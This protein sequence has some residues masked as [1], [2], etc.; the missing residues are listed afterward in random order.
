MEKSRIVTQASEERNYH[1]FYELLDG[2]SKEQKDKYGLMTPEKYFY[3]NQGGHCSLDGKNDKED[4]E[5]LQS[6]MQVLS[7]SSEE[8]E[9]V[10]KI[11]A[12]ILHLGNIFFHRKQLKHGY[13]GVEIGSEA[14]IKWAAHLLQLSVSGIRKAMTMRMTDVRKNENVT[15]PLNIDQALDSRDAIAKALYSSLFTWLVTR[16]NKVMAP[17]SRKQQ[18]HLAQGNVGKNIIS[19]MDMFGFE[20]FAENSFEQLCINYA[21][22]SLQNYVNKH[23]FKHEQAEYAK[24]KIEWTPIPF[25]ENGPILHILAKKPVGVFH[26]LDDESNFPKAS[27]LSFLEKC[28][29][30]H[31]LN[32][33]YSRPRMSSMEFGIKHYAGQVWYNVEGF[34][35]K[36]R[37]TLRYDVMA[38]LISSKVLFL[39]PQKYL[40]IATK[41]FFDNSILKKKSKNR[42]IEK[43]LNIYRKKLISNFFF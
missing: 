15:L 25:Q 38:L 24:E 36:N 33:L 42:F 22:E 9:T 4:F 20:D 32:E 41:R 7:F 27:D 6:A 37:D 30:N 11:L 8:C 2:L 18:Q 12:S 40:L 29:Y 21:D 13:E 23:I 1:I 43:H 5:A 26:L 28:H 34:L 39:K 35:D 3:L 31:A 14:E 10:Y 17:T 16:I 19:I